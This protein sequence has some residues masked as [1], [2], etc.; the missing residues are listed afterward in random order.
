MSY[1]VIIHLL[2][3]DPIVAEMENLPDPQAVSFSCVNPRRRDGK[4]LHYI[5]QECTSFIFPW[6]RVNFVE[7]MPSEEES[8]QI[9]EFF[10]D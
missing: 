9:V 2:N 10:R 3:E 7:V 8:Q 5:D 6:T 4:A 1:T